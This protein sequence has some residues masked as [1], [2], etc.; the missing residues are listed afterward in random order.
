MAQDAHADSILG[1]GLFF[2]WD[3]PHCCSLI[4]D[5][6]WI[7]CVVQAPLETWFTDGEGRTSRRRRMDGTCSEACS[8]K[9]LR[10]ASGVI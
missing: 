7:D 9:G 5:R 3:K 1:A 2:C 10:K 6:F 4:A 8:F